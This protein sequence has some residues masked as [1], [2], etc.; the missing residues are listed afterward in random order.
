MEDAVKVDYRDFTVDGCHSDFRPFRPKNAH[1]DNG[2]A[3]RASSNVL[4]IIHLLLKYNRSPDPPCQTSRIFS[5]LGPIRRKY[6]LPGSAK[7]RSTSSYNRRVEPVLG[8]L[9]DLAVNG[10]GTA[11]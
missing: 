7:T 6:S 5:D 1:V 4:H 3:P 8:D 2:E 11:L 9:V 10:L